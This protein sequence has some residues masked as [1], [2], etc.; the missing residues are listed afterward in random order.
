MKGAAILLLLMLIG[1][2]LY[3]TTGDQPAGP[4]VAA[5]EPAPSS[6]VR[7]TTQGA[8]RGFVGKDSAL[9][10]LGI[11]FAKPPLGELR[12]RPPLPAEP[13]DGVRDVM[14]HGN[15]CP[16]FTNAT[17][18]GLADLEG[19]EDCLYLNIYAPAT[20]SAPATAGDGTG[21]LPVMLWIHGGGNSFGHAGTYDGSRLATS[22]NVV[23]VTTNY[24]LAH[25]GW[26]SHP[27]LLTGDPAH[28]S[29]NFGILDLIAALAWTRDNIAAFG[30]D[31]GNVT[32]FGESAGGY[33]VLALVA[34][35]LA[36]GLFHRAISQSGGLWP[37]PIERVRA[38]AADG[39]DRFSAPEIVNHLL[40]QEGLADDLEAAR[41]LQDGMPRQE[42]AEYL[43]SKTPQELWGF[44]HNARIG[45]IPTPELFGDGHVLPA[46]DVVEVF[47]D[48]ARHN[49][50]PTLLGTNRDEATVWMYADPRLIETAE[51]GK[52][53]GIKD[54]PMYRRLVHYASND[55][56][57]TGVDRFAIALT[58][59]GNPNVYAYRF[60]WD[61][62]GVVD[63][64]DLSAALGASH[65]VEMPF[66]FGDF[67]TGWVMEPI[68]DNS[69]DKEWLA[70]AMMSYWSQFALTG[71][72]GRGR[73]GTLPEWRAW[74]T[75][76]ETTLLLDTPSAGIR[77]MT[78]AL[79][80]AGMKAELAADAQVASR[81]ERCGLYTRLYFG[82]PEFHAEEFA[83]F[84]PDGCEGLD[85][86]QLLSEYRR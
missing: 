41:V 81:V 8:V 75:D 21:G 39:G 84:G 40:V 59:S 70:Q 58:A 77:M 80:V 60:D 45:T 25:L 46:G 2:L 73:D 18:P 15:F 65:A 6:T 17:T 86:V 51:D 54:E 32:I 48:M 26:F 23:V 79:T 72:P 5:T 74:D 31:P 28:D 71:D 10:W 49:S 38:Y 4:D 36:G 85:P 50:V 35:P 78:G 33:D 64:F 14:R 44:F 30:G 42:L 7:N 20:A 83:G 69:P 76:G 34:S 11:P 62:A 61:E 52:R 68:Y 16:Q 1:G 57:E 53:I 66:V 43:R 3:W 82:G 12:W 24:R 56:K 47:S 27:T 19:D 63:G 9:T 37:Y 67:T 55:W 13:W 29:G 22:Q